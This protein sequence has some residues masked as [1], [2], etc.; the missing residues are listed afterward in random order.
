M[1]KNTKNTTPI[2][3][4]NPPNSEEPLAINWKNLEKILLNEGDRYLEEIPENLPINH[5]ITNITNDFSTEET[6][7]ESLKDE[8]LSLKT[9]AKNLSNFFTKAS[10][11][12]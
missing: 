10:L 5:T 8:D 2:K 11:L 9:L 6:E 7:N 12:D 1:I 3:I 4:F